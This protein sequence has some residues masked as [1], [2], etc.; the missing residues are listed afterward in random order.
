MTKYLIVFSMIHGITCFMFHDIT[1]FGRKVLFCS[2]TP[3]PSFQDIRR[4]IDIA[5]SSMSMHRAFMTVKT[6]YFFIE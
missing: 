5:V 2:D 1:K 4:V 6:A 3:L